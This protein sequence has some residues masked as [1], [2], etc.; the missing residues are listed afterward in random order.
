MI[1][2]LNTLKSGSV[3]GLLLS[4][5]SLCNPKTVEIKFNDWFVYIIHSISLKS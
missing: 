1:N 4:K 2:D 5:D 3:T